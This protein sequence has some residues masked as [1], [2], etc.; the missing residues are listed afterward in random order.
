MVFIM[1][2]LSV[3]CVMWCRRDVGNSEHQLFFTWPVFGM[4][5]EDTGWGGGGGPTF[6]L[7]GFVLL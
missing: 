4:N 7:L 6:A 1:N 3:T 2:R 5:I